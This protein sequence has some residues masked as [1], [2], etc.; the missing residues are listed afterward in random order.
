MPRI[1]EIKCLPQYF[2][3]TAA[4]RKGFEIRKNDRG[5]KIGDLLAM[6][7]YDGE[8]YTGRALLLKVDYMM[9]P[10]DVMICGQGYV[11]MGVHPVLVRDDSLCF[12]PDWILTDEVKKDAGVS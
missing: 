6:N 5:Y 11:V 9:D 7:E 4:G 1:H 3:E 12:P 2:E 8:K 10:N